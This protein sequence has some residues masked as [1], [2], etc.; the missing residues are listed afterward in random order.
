MGKIKEFK[1]ALST[2]SHSRAGWDYDLPPAQRAK[3]NREEKEAISLARSI[4]AE[5]PGMHD[6]LRAA[7]AEANPLATMREIENLPVKAAPEVRRTH[8]A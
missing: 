6:D 2:I 7:F 8:S 3:E 4:W 5:N 1:A